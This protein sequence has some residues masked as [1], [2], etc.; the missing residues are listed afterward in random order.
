A[1]GK[2]L[3][4]VRR[5][6]LLAQHVVDAQG[7]GAGAQHQGSFR[8]ETRGCK[9][10]A[11]SKTRPLSALPKLKPQESCSMPAISQPTLPFTGLVRCHT[12]AKGVG[13]APAC[14]RI[15]PVNLT[16]AQCASPSVTT[17]SSAASSVTTSVCCCAPTRERMSAASESN[18]VSVVTS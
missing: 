15:W 16:L 6:L 5:P 4:L 1:P 7:G 12:S 8:V 9:G 17:S 13:A 3:E 10:K 2:G 18:S 11:V 14:S